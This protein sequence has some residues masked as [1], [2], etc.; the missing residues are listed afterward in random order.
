VK[1][2]PLNPNFR[3]KWGIFS[4]KNTVKPILAQFFGTTYLAHSASLDL[5]RQKIGLK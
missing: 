4:H 1:N 2:G 5:S 3:Q